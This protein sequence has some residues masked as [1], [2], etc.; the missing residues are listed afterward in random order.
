KW[1]EQYDQPNLIRF[2]GGP[3]LSS[4]AE[5]QALSQG[6]TITQPDCNLYP[7]AF[8]LY[9]V[10]SDGRAYFGRKGLPSDDE[11]VF[12]IAV[13]QGPC[14]AT[15]RYPDGHTTTLAEPLAAAAGFSPGV[16]RHDPALGA[17]WYSDAG[18]NCADAAGPPPEWCGRCES[19][20]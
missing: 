19:P 12:V 5:M 18:G 13:P 10:G 16:L 20:W 6:A 1:A 11:Y 7:T 9:N 15:V 3:A 8:T 4:P 2:L 14:S 17:I